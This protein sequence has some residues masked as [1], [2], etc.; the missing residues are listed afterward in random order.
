MNLS[1]DWREYLAGFG[2][3][4][5]HWS[6]LGAATAPDRE[7]LAWAK[8]LTHV[9]L[10]HDLDFGAILAVTNAAGPSVI[11]IRSQDVSPTAV[12]SLVVTALRTHGEVLE[13]GALVTVDALRLRVRI[14]P[15]PPE[16]PSTNP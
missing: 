2:H 12:G 16:F 10:T 14:L 1:P 13:H 9:V 15:L 3:Q 7:I 4:A 5:A 8:S 6:E 11:Q